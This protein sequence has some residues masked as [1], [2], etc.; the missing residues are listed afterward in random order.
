MKFIKYFFEFII[1]IS[2]FCIFKIIG[3]RNASNLGSIFGK[4]IGPFFRSKNLIK[5][6]IKNGLGNID[7]NQE[8]KIID[9]MWSNI[10]RTFA[11]YV[12]LKD[13]RFD[14]TD[15]DHMKIIGSEHLEEIKKSNKPVIFYSAHLANFELMAMELEKFGIKIAAIYRPLNN[16]FL[17]PIMEYLR[18]KYIC[19]NQIPKGRAGMREIINKITNN[20]SIALMVDQRVGEG[21]KINF[22][23][24][25]A[26][27]TTI[28]AQL[29]LRYNCKLV[30]ISLKRIENINFE[31][32]VHK[33]YEIAKT[34]NNEQDTQN[35]TLKIN[36]IIEKM[37]I[38]NPTQ[39][40]WSHNRWK[41]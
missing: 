20:Y 30:P 10:G 33:P 25:P 17:N 6:N 38:E 35:I 3:L 12:F 16:L 9:G 41:L 32:T 13:F 1:I 28:P 27:T 29:A 31:M 21:E 15:F 4:S 11:E 19:P 18:M 26:Q 23:N 34:S 8:R 22:F 5:K 24:Q 37:I 36:Q 39:W 14:K 7:E 40:L 2:L